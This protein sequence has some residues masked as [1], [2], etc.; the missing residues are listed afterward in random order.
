MSTWWS[1]LSDDELRARL[2]Q[3]GVDESAARFLVTHRED[4]LA[5]QVIVELLGN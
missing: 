4:P 2:V 3:R 1:E 5:A